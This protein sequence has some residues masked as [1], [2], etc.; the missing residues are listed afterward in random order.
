MTDL[1]YN[2][3]VP[4]TLNIKSFV[5]PE[6]PDPVSLPMYLYQAIQLSDPALERHRD[7]VR[8]VAEDL[9]ERQVKARERFFYETGVTHER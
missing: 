6:M 2:A 9:F 8:Q 3:N 1:A 5:P 7:A 4:A